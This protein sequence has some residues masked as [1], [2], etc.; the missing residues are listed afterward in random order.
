LSPES[1]VGKEYAPFTVEVEKGRLRLFAK[2]I[3]ET[4]PIYTDEDAARAAGYPSL[5][6]PPTF[7]FSLIMDAEQPL[8][9]LEDLQVDKTKT[10]HG[11][12]GFIYHR[13]ICAGDR[14]T[15]R[16]RVLETYEKKNG[17]F[18]FVV[19]ETKL[20]NQHHQPTADLRTVIIIR[21]K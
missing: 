16:Q 11:E 18:R 7:A 5:P 14:I 19:T 2:A 17:V 4:N 1:L 15:G 12:Q 21:Q 8:K 13:P 6:A 10:M 20:E 9:V 3:G